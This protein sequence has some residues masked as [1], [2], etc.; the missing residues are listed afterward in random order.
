VPAELGP[1]GENVPASC[2]ARN[3]EVTHVRLGALQCHVRYCSRSMTFTRTFVGA[4]G[5]AFSALR[6]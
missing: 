3:D 6:P 1:R 2:A 5:R 4:A